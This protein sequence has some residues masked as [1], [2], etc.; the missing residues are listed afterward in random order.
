MDTLEDLVCGLQTEDARGSACFYAKSGASYPLNLARGMLTMAFLRKH[1]TAVVPSDKTCRASNP[2]LTIE[3]LLTVYAHSR[4]SAASYAQS[5]IE[6]A[7]V[8][9][10][11]AEKAAHLSGGML[12]RLILA[13]ELATEP[14]FIILCNPLQ[15]LDIQA[16][17]DM[18]R[19]IVQL[20]KG[21]KAV[22]LAGAAD[23]PLSLCTR[24]YTLESGVCT[25]SFTKEAAA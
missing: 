19:T 5:L 12:Q 3:Q 7:G 22:L 17:T 18:I 11:S 8:R 20:A 1:K 23:F 9:I 16:Q 13:R 21:G 2:R 25:L 4:R 14:D 6:Q 10:T 24:V 15:G